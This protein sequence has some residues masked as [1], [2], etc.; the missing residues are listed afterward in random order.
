META[1]FGSP[2]HIGKVDQP[3]GHRVFG[4]EVRPTQQDNAAALGPAGTVHCSILDWGRFAALHLRGARGKAKLLK[5]ATFRALHT[6]PRGNSYAGGWSVVERSW[7]NGRALT[8]SGS[9]TAWH[10]TIWIA[11]ARYLAILTAT[12]EGGDSASKACD[13][14]V[15]RLIESSE[16]LA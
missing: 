4:D 15:T 12:N 8:H 10:V 16:F 3:W 2:G 13:Q 11:P 1:G 7:A 5:P 9:N 14:A 6:P